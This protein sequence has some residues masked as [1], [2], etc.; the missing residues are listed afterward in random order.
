MG[1]KK[2][3]VLASG[4]GTNLQ[5][6]MD[7]IKSGR[8]KNADLRLVVSDNPKA[9]ALERARASGIEALWINPAA[10]PGREEYNRELIEQLRKRQ[11]D[12]VV[13]AGYMRIL[14]PEF[15]KAYKNAIINIHP[16]LIPSFC[17]KGYYGE[18]VH[19]EALEYGVKVTGATVHF[20][21]EGTDTG[22]IILQQAVE[23]LPEDTVESLAERVLKVEHI[24]LPRAVDLY[25]RGCL[26]IEGRRVWIKAD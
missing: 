26:K 12:L 21:D 3:A 15:V 4:R 25:C 23:V 24:L 7:G 18:R 6:V 20:V 14:S 2:I 10:F 8:V 13:L 9:Y 22:P 5:S 1:I 11:V 16:S 19:R 17:G